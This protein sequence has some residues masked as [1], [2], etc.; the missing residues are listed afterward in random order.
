MPE[1]RNKPGFRKFLKITGYAFLSLGIIASGLLAWYYFFGPRWIDDYAR[2]KV[3]KAFADAA[4][5]YSLKIKKLHCDIG[6]N[7]ITF[8]SVGISHKDS[9]LAC[10]LKNLTVKKIDWY[11]LVSGDKEWKAFINSSCTMEGL[12]IR[13]PK[14]DY[15]LK[16]RHIRLSAADSSF[17]ADEVELQPLYEDEDFF[18]LSEFRRTRFKMLASSFS[19]DGYSLQRIFSKKKYEAHSVRLDDIQ[20]D[21]LLNKEKGLDKK[22]TARPEMPQ[23]FLASLSI[24]LQVDSLVINNCDIVYGER[25]VA[26]A[27]P[28]ILTFDN[29]SVKVTG[30]KTGSVADTD[31]LYINIESDFQNSCKGVVRLAIPMISERPD[32][33]YSGTL[34]A[35]DARKLNSFLVIAERHKIKSGNIRGGKFH[36]MVRDGN[37]KGALLIM[38]DDLYVSILDKKT[39]SDKGI[40]NKIFSFIANTF[41]FRTENLPEDGEPAV[42]G[43]INYKA[44]RIDAFLEIFWFSLRSGL[45]DVVGF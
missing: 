20:M 37:V 29:T 42:P 17:D 32:F 30:I 44:K 26:K 45:A 2:K 21:I 10:F 25:V 34:T 16:C 9:S 7:S 3:E 27:P 8:D 23:Q 39:G 14:K 11:D 12:N 19:I 43:K 1:T 33:A 38:Y 6:N 36:A 31:S 15:G 4:P 22:D 28:G 40:L 24:P 18:S 5:G 41:K 35:L 13:L